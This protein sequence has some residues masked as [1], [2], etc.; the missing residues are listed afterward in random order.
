MPGNEI[1]IAEGVETALAVMELDC[2]PCWAAL[3]A[4]RLGRVS[5]PSSV[6]RIHLYA[7]NDRAGKACA[8]KAAAA[9]LM[10]GF[11][12]TIHSPPK[13]VKDFAD[14]LTMKDTLR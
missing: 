10:Q 2:R 1:G 6:K 13:A 8:Q 4:Q 12:V 7:D 14:A 5:V 9:F 3:G 11:D